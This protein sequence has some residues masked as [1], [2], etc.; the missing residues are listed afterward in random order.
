MPIESASALM[1]ATKRRM[2]KNSSRRMLFGEYRGISIAHSDAGGCYFNAARRHCVCKR[3]YRL[4]GKCVI[5]LLK[6][7]RL[8]DKRCRDEMASIELL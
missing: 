6:C 1:P 8:E 2:M 7:L 5:R 3:R 4:A